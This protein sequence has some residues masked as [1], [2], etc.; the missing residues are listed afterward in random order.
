[1]AFPLPRMG[2]ENVQDQLSA[3]D[4]TPPHAFFKIAKLSGSQVM[5][6]DHKRDVAHFRFDA[7]FVQL[8]A[9][10]QSC[11]IKRVPDLQDR[12]FN[13]GTGALCELLELL[14]RITP[15]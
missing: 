15:G 2:G 8:T 5:V 3:I 6:N 11:W 14:K 10:H 12:S 1:M 7:D 4:H 13:L 9:T